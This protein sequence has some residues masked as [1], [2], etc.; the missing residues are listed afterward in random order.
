MT[1]AFILVLA[2]RASL[3]VKVDG[4][5]YFRFAR[6]GR[7]VYAKS[8]K[9]VVDHG[10][11]CSAEGPSLV[12]EMLVSGTPDS[13]RVTLAGDV[14]AHYPQG[15][16][17]VGRI[18]L[19]QFAADV[20]PV[21]SKGFLICSGKGEVGEAGQ[22]LFG[23]VR[24]VADAA[25]PTV[26]EIKIYDADSQPVVQVSPSKATDLR[27]LKAGGVKVTL[28]DD[29]VVEGDEV[30]LGEVANVSANADAVAKVAA[31]PVAESPLIGVTTSVTRA[32]IERALAKA[33]L[34]TKT[35]DI[36]GP[37]QVRVKR[38]F[39]EIDQ[40]NFVKAALE[41]SRKQLGDNIKPAFDSSRPGPLKAPKGDIEFEVENIEVHGTVAACRVVAKVDGKRINSRTVNLK[42]EQAPSVVKTRPGDVVSVRVVKNGVSVETRG[43]VRS[44]DTATGR[45]T[46]EVEPSK[47][48]VSGQLM[49]DGSVEVKA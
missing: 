38:A 2:A 22:G 42:V 24:T 33:G 8:A 10:R 46:V 19:V 20:R 4:E 17:K 40:E 45:V 3:D 14:Y 29:V 23:V 13:L 39:Q 11:L 21:E 16:N 44:V 5:G 27:F 41:Q 30:L 7:P 28:Y 12:P 34:D 35:L 48:M 49:P 47:S 6:D 9:L 18:V 1:A 43:R 15:E 31:L 37:P 36:E 25:A 26:P 32:E